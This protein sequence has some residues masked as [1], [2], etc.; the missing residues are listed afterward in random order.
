MNA[1]EFFDKVVEMRKAQQIYFRYKKFADLQRSKDIEKEIDKEIA[2]V[3]EAMK[4]KQP[5]QAD[6]FPPI[7][8]QQ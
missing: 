5:T 7:D 6:L 8:E 2:R 1:K 3:Q 4:P